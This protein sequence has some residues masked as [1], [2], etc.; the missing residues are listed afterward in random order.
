V[1]AVRVVPADLLAPRVRHDDAPVAHP[2]RRPHAVHLVQRVALRHAY[3]QRRLV[4][5]PPSAVLLPAAAAVLDDLDACAVPHARGAGASVTATAGGEGK[6][7]E[8]AEEVDRLHGR[9]G[10]GGPD[11]DVLLYF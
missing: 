7:R 6:E 8:D 9:D 10:G 2:Q 4:R 1:A 3:L 11:A 5:E